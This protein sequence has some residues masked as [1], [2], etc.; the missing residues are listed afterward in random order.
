MSDRLLIDTTY[1]QG[2]LSSNDPLRE[3]AKVLF[4][5]VQAAS[6]VLITEAVLMEI[7]NALAQVQDRQKAV[8]FINACYSGGATNLKVVPI[9][10]ELIQRSL[11]LFEERQDKTWSLTD[12]MSILVMQDND[13]QDAVTTDRHFVQA[14]LNALML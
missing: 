12:C 8:D 13:I 9:N 11:K 2:L 4:S 1:I 6:L 3:T 5:R 10:T 7:G 14:G